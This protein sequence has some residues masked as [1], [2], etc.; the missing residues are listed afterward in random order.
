MILIL[1]KYL[2]GIRQQWDITHITCLL[3]GFPN[4]QISVIITD[5]MFGFQ[6]F[7]IR[8]RQSGENRKNE[9]IPYLCQSGNGNTLSI[10]AFIS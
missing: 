10:I 1:I 4:P 3:T 8:K 9:N 2:L 7:Q 5:K 6:L